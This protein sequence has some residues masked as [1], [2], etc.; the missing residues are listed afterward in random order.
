M[1]TENKMTKNKTSNLTI[2]LQPTLKINNI[3]FTSREIDIIAC[4]AHVRGV[5]KIANILDISP[6]T[7]EGHIKNILVK[8]NHHSQESI[9]DFVEYSS[10][11][12]SIKNHYINLQ[13]KQIFFWQLKLV[14]HKIHKENVIY[15][16]NCNDSKNLEYIADLLSKCNLQIIKQSVN[17]KYSQENIILE[18]TLETIDKLKEVADQQN[19]IWIFFD[20]KLAD[21]VKNINN[22]RIIDC[23]TYDRVYEV[24]FKIIQILHP[25]I[26]FDKEISKFSVLRNNITQL[27]TNQVNNNHNLLTPESHKPKRKNIMLSIIISIAVIVIVLSATLY[28]KSFGS[29]LNPVSINFVLPS[30]DILLMRTGVAKKLDK[31]LH[32]NKDINIAVL[33][34][35]GGSGK[36][37]IARNYAQ[38]QKASIIWEINAE[39]LNSIVLSFE[40]L[41]YVL[42]SNGEEKQ[43]LRSI[44]DIKNSEK[45][46]NQLLLFT[47]NKL[48]A[49][50]NWL[51]VYDNAESMQNINRYM[52]NNKES[53][54]NGRVIITTRDANI[55]NNNYID[56]NN[57]IAIGEITSEEKL[58]L[59]SNIIKGIIPKPLHTETETKEFLE[60]IPSFPLD[61]SIAAHYLKDTGMQY[62]KY[63]AEITVPQKEFTDLQKTI[64]QDSSYYNQTRYNIVSLTLKQ[65]LDFNSEFEDLYLLSGLLDSQEIPQELLSLYKNEYVA[66][67]FLRS[68]NKNSLITNIKHKN[69]QSQH[70]ENLSTFSIHRSTQSNILANIINSLSDLGKQEKLTR[71]LDVLQSYIL[72]E[73]DIDNSASLKNLIRHC[74]SIESKQNLLNIKNIESINNSL[75][76]IYY[77]LGHDQKAKEILESNLDPKAMD[78]E[79]A[80][81][82]THLGAIYRKL[83]QDYKKGLEYLNKAILIY[84]KISP[85]S[86]REALALTH[87]GNTY[88]TLGNFSKAIKSL[89]RSVNI[90]HHQSGYYA[91]EA[92]ALGYLGVAYREQSELIKAKELLEEAVKIY[93]KE[94][95]PKYSAVYA[96][97]L[98]HLGITYRMMEEYTKAQEILEASLAIYEQIRPKDHPDIGRNILNLGIIYGE[99]K[100]YNTAQEMLIKSLAD[101][102]RNY[103]ENHIETGKILNHL[104]RFY[105]LSQNFSKAEELLIRAREILQN[106]NHPESYRSFELLG[107]LYAHQK[108]NQISTIDSYQKS[109][110]QALRHFDKNSVN[111]KRL[112]RRIQYYQEVK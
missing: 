11:L 31:L 62:N 36:T 3:L 16:I 111:V 82:L 24:V 30:K 48:K 42:C 43:E 41:A 64:L 73:I 44:L 71:I 79:T 84:D 45:K 81:T 95:Y 66:K 93:K 65:M 86:P 88:R 105:T 108:V 49:L 90:Y 21:S 60:Q 46:D 22:A 74:Q 96:G 32:K 15:F 50:S 97:T 26:C 23:S 98:A 38:N 52:P 7:I 109:L 94:N 106:N 12:L 76:F 101:Y 58:Q 13:I 85:D 17:G 99:M 6:R 54:G 63:L 59:F 112:Q 18:L 14:S 20:N 37:T 69:S 78:Q 5:K 9:K 4:I 92:R 2:V 102:E 19:F 68:L 83:G 35:G 1:V 56:K 28:S 40:N 10:E 107:D 87:L 67:N 27:T 57:I 103:G 29:G 47:Q 91:G 77:Y 80:L 104:G 61:V 25:H 33:V 39:T 110:E 100:E 53:W 72:H 34:G 70:I 75:G 51:I 89:E 55:Q 8:I